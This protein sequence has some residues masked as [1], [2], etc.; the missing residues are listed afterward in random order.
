MATTTPPITAPG[1][2]SGLDV[3][4]LIDKLVAVDKQPLVNLQQREAG[5]QAQ[6]SAFGSLKGSLSTLQSAMQNLSTVSS[7]QK[8]SADVGDTMLLTA[9]ATSSVAAGTHTIDVQ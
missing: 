2:G 9:S 8:V 3:N 5:Y 4:S 1:V 6:L 7:F